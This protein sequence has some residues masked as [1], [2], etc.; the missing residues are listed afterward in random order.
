M[1]SLLFYDL[2]KTSTYVIDRKRDNEEKLKNWFC[3]L[4]RTPNCR[5]LD[6]QVIGK[7]LLCIPLVALK[8]VNVSCWMA[9][10]V[11]L[12]LLAFSS[13]FG[14]TNPLSAK[15][16]RDHV[17][18]R[19]IFSRSLLIP[20][21][22]TTSLEIL[23][24]EANAAEPITQAEVDGPAAR[25]QRM[26]R[27]KP[28][29]ILR[30][31][32]NQDFAVLLMRSSYNAL[33]ELDCVAMDQFQ[34][35]FFLIRSSEYEPY[36]ESLGPGLV[37]Q[38]DLTD[39]YYFDFISFAQYNAINREVMVSPRIFFEEQ[40]PVDVGPSEPQKF[41]T[42]VVRRDPEISNDLLVPEHSRRVGFAIFHKLEETFR[43]TTSALPLSEAGMKLDAGKSNVLRS[44]ITG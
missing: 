38:G 1:S 39:P 19:S 33:D 11:G 35:D 6:H 12:Y 26:L 40:Q 24:G 2:N 29:K 44:S 31:K 27:S 36:T 22:G 5:L 13:L 17:S 30:P 43:G 18:R 37:K 25:L 42:K 4:F 23:K 20:L 10:R 34:R 16:H 41:I 32:L 8:F 14:L 21:L 28:P 15:V 7:V 3:V 9:K